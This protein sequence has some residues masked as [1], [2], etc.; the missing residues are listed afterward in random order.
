MDDERCGC[1]W[2]DWSL[3]LTCCLLTPVL[4]AGGNGGGGMDEGAK[5]SCPCCCGRAGIGG[6]TGRELDEEGVDFERRTGIIFT[7]SF[8]LVNFLFSFS[9][10]L[11][12]SLVFSS[13]TIPLL[14]W[15]LLKFLSQNWRRTRGWEAGILSA[16]FK[17]EEVKGQHKWVSLMDEGCKTFS[18]FSNLF[19][20][21]FL[22]VWLF[23]Q[24]P[25][26]WYFSPFFSRIF[27]PCV[28]FPPLSWYFFRYS[29][30]K[31]ERNYVESWWVWK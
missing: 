28:S 27:L 15:Y 16:L 12:I 19:P 31:P 24:L 8:L 9:S 1:C 20:W 29:C 30:F 18:P 4:L 14:S 22:L 6:G 26:S 11:P 2:W 3:L 23:R 21:L 7:P 25:F 10:F 13:M 17:K 5:N